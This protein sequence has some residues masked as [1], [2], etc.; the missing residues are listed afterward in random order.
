M[1]KANRKIPIG[2]RVYHFGRKQYGVL[3]DPKDFLADVSSSVVEFD[4]GECCEV[5][6]TFLEEAP[7]KA[8]GK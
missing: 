1:R 8:E 7:A 6:S 3:L 2:S 4:D 5:S